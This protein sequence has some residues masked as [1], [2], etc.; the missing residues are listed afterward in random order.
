[1]KLHQIRSDYWEVCDFF[2]PAFSRSRLKLLSVVS[3]CLHRDACRAVWHKWHV[4]LH[5]RLLPKA[6]ITAQAASVKTEQITQ[7]ALGFAFPK[8][9]LDR[10]LQTELP[11]LRFDHVN[12]ACVMISVFPSCHF[13]PRL[14]SSTLSHLSEKYLRCPGK[15]LESE[16]V[17]VTSLSR[18]GVSWETHRHTVGSG[19]LI[20][21]WFA[22]WKR[23]SSILKLQTDTSQHTYTHCALTLVRFIISNHVST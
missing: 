17:T 3:V 9:Q 23:P 10:S 2:S 13:F 22:L 19:R 1:M 16:S 5:S 11:Q 8:G 7:S 14:L 6:D 4:M 15:V 12:V 20:L 21:Y 18:A